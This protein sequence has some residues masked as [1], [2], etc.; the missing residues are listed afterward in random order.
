MSEFKEPWRVAAPDWA[1]SH[2]KGDCFDIL[3]ADG[4]SAII[5]CGE[6][7]VLLGKAETY[8]RIVAC[9][10]ACAGVPTEELEQLRAKLRVS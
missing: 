10:N 8:R 2:H 7:G 6:C 4:E 1:G 3:G 9:V 5:A